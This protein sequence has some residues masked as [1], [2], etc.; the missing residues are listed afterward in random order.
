MYRAKTKEA[1]QECAVKVFKLKDLPDDSEE[2]ILKE[3]S[4]LSMLDHPGIIKLYA[5]FVVGDDFLWMV[6]PL[7]SH[8]SVLDVMRDG[9]YATG[10]PEDCIGAILGPTLEA[11]AYLH[12][13]SGIHRDLKGSSLILAIIF[14]SFHFFSF[15]FLN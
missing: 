2:R 14:V 11:L 1:A 5:S 10:L 15:F 8:G 3:I 4:T 9:A 7:I 13:G 6:M 12:S